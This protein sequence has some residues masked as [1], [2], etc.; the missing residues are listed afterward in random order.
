M[1]STNTQG[2]SANHDGIF[3]DRPE[4]DTTYITHPVT[5]V[6]FGP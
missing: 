1:V 5:D 3:S 6:K 4:E 2:G